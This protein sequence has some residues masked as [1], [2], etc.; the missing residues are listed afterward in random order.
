MGQNWSCCLD[1]Y[2]K[3][4]EACTT[5]QNRSNSFTVIQFYNTKP[6]NSKSPWEA[7]FSK[8]VLSVQLSFHEIALGHVKSGLNQQ[9]FSAKQIPLVP[10][11]WH[12]PGMVFIGSTWQSPQGPQRKKYLNGNFLYQEHITGDPHG[13]QQSKPKASQPS[14]SPGGNHRMLPVPLPGSQGMDQINTKR[15]LTS[16]NVLEDGYKPWVQITV[17]NPLSFP[18]LQFGSI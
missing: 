13:G 6:K 10:L 2:F 4:Q 14:P 5:H 3:T 7:M 12:L 9:H 18:W 11:L 16:M 1:F 17:S 15:P 8:P